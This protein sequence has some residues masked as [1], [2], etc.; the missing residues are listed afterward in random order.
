MHCKHIVFGGSSDNGYARLLVPYSGN[1]D[2]SS[3]ITLL[4]G[5]PFAIP[6]MRNLTK[7]FAT[8][9]FPNIFRNSKLISQPHR[10]S[11][12]QNHAPAPPDLTAPVRTITPKTPTATTWA[13][14]SKTPAAPGPPPTTNGPLTSAKFDTYDYENDPDE[15]FVV[16]QNSKG[17]RID[18]ILPKLKEGLV[19]NQK[20]RKLCNP[21]Q[22]SGFCPREENGV[23]CPYGHDKLTIEEL[24][25]QRYIARFQMCN[26][27]L[28][29]ENEYCVSGHA[30]PYRICTLGSECK[31]PKYMHNVSRD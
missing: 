28:D 26:G 19:N 16:L 8:I 4:E 12:T 6:E 31:Y 29:C 13:A 10:A 24:D 17:E 11:F 1:E 27:G 7:K 25:A 14:V 20:R 21:F 2:V 3:R 30:C 9:S 15:H 22:L 5:P 18:S 23:K